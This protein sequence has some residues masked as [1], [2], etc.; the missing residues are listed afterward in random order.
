MAPQLVAVG[1]PQLVV[2]LSPAVKHSFGHRRLEQVVGLLLIPHLVLDRI[3]LH[4]RPL[5]RSNIVP[6]R[7]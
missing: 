1:R 7:G 3:E 6:L 2:A 4:G 5:V